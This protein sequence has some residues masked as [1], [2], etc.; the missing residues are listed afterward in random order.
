MQD[1]SAINLSDYLRVIDE[2]CGED[3]WLFRGQHE[4]WSM[5]PKLARLKVK[6]DDYRKA[7]KNM[8]SELRRNI[9]Q[10]TSDQ[11]ANDWDLLSIAQ[12]HGMA[13]RL[14]DWSLSP[15][16]ALWFAIEH[17]PRDTSK[18]A[19]V[20]MIQYTDED[21]ISDPD[22]V[23]PFNIERTMYFV[24]Y[25]RTSRIRVQRGY[26]SV[27]Q[28]TEDHR[29]LPLQEQPA[30]AD[31]L[32]RIEITPRNFSDIRFDLDRC[33][34]NRAAMFPDLDGLC[35]YLTWSYSLDEDERD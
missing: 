3:N 19:V 28:Q 34:I 21:L 16:V 17:P 26:F 23:S 8:I 32:Y 9:A 22:D 13:T 35:S 10:Y 24:P 33:G 15:L 31:R 30:F 29:W 5:L 18:N 20:Y 11:P 14:L 6:Q 25:I 12:H 1:L 7:E 4:D 2:Y 27:H